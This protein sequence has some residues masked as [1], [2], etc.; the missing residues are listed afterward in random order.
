MNELSP[1][2]DETP[3]NP[4]VEAALQASTD[5]RAASL[6]EFARIPSISALPEHAAD[7]VTAAEWVADRLRR[8]GATDVEVAATA[9]HPIVYGRIHEAPGAPVVLVYCHY[10]VQPADPLDLWE[11]APFE[12][13][14]RDGRFVGRGVADDKGQLVM[15]LS[16]LEAIRAVG[17]AP[18]VNLTFV[19][20]GEEEYGSDSLYGWIAANR[21]R[22]AADVA[23][24]SDTGYFEGNLPAITVGLRGIMYAQIDVELSPVDLHSGM[25]GGTVDN[26]ANALAR[27]IA[28]LMGAD[29]RIRIPGF[30]DDVVALTPADREA[31]AALPFDEEAY[32]AEIPVPA[33]VGESGWTTMERRG[34]RPTLDVNGMWSGFQGEGAKTIIPAHAHAKI[35][36]RLVANQDAHRVYEALRDYVAAIASPGVK[37]TTTFIHGG[38]PSLTPTDHPAT[39]AAARALRAVHGVDPVYIREGGSIPVTAAF[40][41]TLGLPVVLLGFCQPSCNAHAPNEWLDLDNFELGTRV[42]VRVWDELAGLPR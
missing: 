5:A 15:H 20:E 34:G 9:L 14:L 28:A 27:I 35:S 29:G 7:M 13:F 36:T 3:I 26:P 41:H 40:D 8:V 23:V 16:A 24:I 10:D 37:V 30:Y 17:L 42:I 31:M 22:L 21:D 11:T 39:R 33:L 6:L 2:P 18:A 25:Y 12:P 19:F 38:E 32:R 4:A 1:A